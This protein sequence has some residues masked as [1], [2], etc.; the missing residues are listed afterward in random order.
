MYHLN[1]NLAVFYDDQNK[2]V[3]RC[4]A[5]GYSGP[6]LHFFAKRH[7]YAAVIMTQSEREVL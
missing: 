6:Q 4:C 1:H 2:N 3:C 5:A 7:V